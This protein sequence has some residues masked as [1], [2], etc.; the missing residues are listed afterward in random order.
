MFAATFPDMANRPSFAPGSLER[1]IAIRG[2]TQAAFAEA[3]R[4]DTE[5]L[6]RANQGKRL[7]TKSFGK[8]LAALGSIPAI[9]GPVDLVVNA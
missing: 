9:D 6:T 3:A 5:T 8:I 7:H 4:V 1:E 2:L